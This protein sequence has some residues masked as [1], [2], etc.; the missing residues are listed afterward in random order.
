MPR[1]KVRV[2][3]SGGVMGSTQKDAIHVDFWI[4]EFMHMHAA[5]QGCSDMAY[6][7][8]K[9]KKYTDMLYSDGAAQGSLVH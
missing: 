4:Q 8:T 5:T 1:V 3:G 9:T 7:C 2:A 6:K